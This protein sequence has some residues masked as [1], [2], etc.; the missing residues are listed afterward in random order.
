MLAIINGPEQVM[1]E[2]LEDINNQ[3]FN[4]VQ[5]KIV[6]AGLFY[7]LEEAIENGATEEYIYR[8]LHSL[9]K[10]YS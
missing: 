2:I 5:P 6:A 3:L 7:Q 1:E 10:E 8:E 4:C 9:I